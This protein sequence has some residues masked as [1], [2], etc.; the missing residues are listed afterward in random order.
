MK[1]NS[2]TPRDFINPLL[3]KRAVNQSDFTKFKE[4][5]GVL[6][7][8]NR[9][10][11]EEHQKNAVRDFLHK[12]FDYVVNTKNRIDLAIFKNSIV[13]VII[14]A[15]SLDNKAEM[16]TQND[17]NKKAFAEAIKYFFDERSSGNN[18]IKHIIILTAFEW[19][20]FDAKD[21]E[22][23]FWQDKDFRKIH[24]DYTNPN[25]LL[26]KTG[27]VYN[28]IGKLVASKK[29]T[30]D[31]IDDLTIECAYFNLKEEQSDKSLLAIYKLLSPDALLKQFNP[32]DANSLNREFYSELLYI[33]GLEEVKKGSKKLIGR[34]KAPQNG[35]FYE[36]IA[37]KLSQYGKPNDFETIIKLII[38]WINRILF[39]KLLE[40]QIVKWNKNPD[41]K[42]LNHTKINDFDKLEMLF[43]EILA[44]KPEVRKHR[45][46]DYI[47]YL[48]S[49]LFEL[50]TEE[51]R[52]LKIS[53][54]SDDAIIEYFPK[55]IIKD[56]KTDKKSGSV[57]TLAYLFEFLDAYDFGSVSSDELAAD[58]GKTL[59][60]AS[61]L[62]LIFE[63]INGYKDGSFYTPSFITMYMARESLQ[64]SVIDRFNAAFIDLKAENW[65]ELVKYC[66]KYSHKDEFNVQANSLIDSI[67][68]CD[69][70]VGSGHFLV[71]V[72]N[73]IIYI[74]YQLGL[75]HIKG[76]RID[77]ANDEL[78]IK[79]DDEWFEYSKP[80]DFKNSNHLTQ[81]L[82]F[83][84]KQRIIE[85]QLFGV[86]INPNS[87]QITK[88]RLWIELLK[89]SYYDENYQLVTLP[90]I[91]INIKTG[92]SLISRFDLK[93][94]LKINNIKE[95]IKHY[96]QA[97]IEYKENIGSKKEVMASIQNLKDK[98]RLTLKA[99][100]KL[101]KELN[102]KLKAYVSEYGYDKLSDSL[103]VLAAMSRY[104]QTASLFGDEVDTKKQAKLLQELTKLETQIDEIEKGKIYENAFEWRFE[105]PEVLDSDGNFVGFDIVIGNP[106]YIMEDDNK[107]AFDGLRDKLCYQGKTDIWHLFSCQGL[108]IL[109]TNGLISYIAKNQWLESRSASNMRKSIYQNGNILSIIDFGTNMVFEEASQQT[110]VFFIKKDTTNLTHQIAYKKVINNI[111]NV[112]IAKLLYQV[113]DENLKN[114]I[115]EIPKLYDEKANLTFSSSQNEEILTKIEIYYP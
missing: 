60:N 47:P 89:N 22:K 80:R 67:T 62:G 105:F 108:D 58:T 95:E 1:L 24:D 43:F 27:D 113:E 92:N 42:F 33:L 14:E 32:N 26:S 52:S 106:P 97:V 46:F 78:L 73:E 23:L 115:K 3:S 114:T 81:K 103:A 66:E 16:I 9:S 48:N 50:H 17:I 30:T 7:E 5:L 109:K 35:S 57:S 19:F 39:L 53:N 72:L 107:S 31:L 10:E 84:E 74:K 18:N 4:H 13:E 70:A 40:S 21:F 29:S 41:H 64:K 15:K 25:I 86:D 11:S 28:K 79:L 38:I 111:P 59:I 51:E 99:E 110:M 54:L 49:S 71:S 87:T 96:K 76:L 82:L 88:L 104:G 101:T 36:N 61:V 45:E 94:E 8:V 83:E 93:D 102:D 77:L 65:N 98:F 56:E 75:L 63:K 91:D 2:K 6:L 100:Y 90:N 44:K 12:S 55:T 68:V 34:A 20:V 112:E 85:N 37:D 69:P